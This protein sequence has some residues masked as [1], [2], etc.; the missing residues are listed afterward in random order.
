MASVNCSVLSR[1]TWFLGSRLSPRPPAS[2]PVKTPDQKQE[3]KLE[4]PNTRKREVWWP[5]S[6]LRRSIRNRTAVAPHFV[7]TV[8][9]ASAHCYF[10][11]AP[12]PQSFRIVPV[13]SPHCCR[14]PSTVF[15]LV[16]NCS[17]ATQQSISLDF[18]FE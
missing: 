12:F 2:L 1:S 17:I 13:V 6:A 10:L 7:H 16:R 14:S 8:S 15:F 11:S 18:S 3:Y 4:R 5:R 9:A